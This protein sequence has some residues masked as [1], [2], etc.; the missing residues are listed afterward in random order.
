MSPTLKTIGQ[1]RSTIPRGGRVRK[2][3]TQ[4]V[5]IAVVGGAGHVGLPLSL[6]L[7][8]RGFHLTVIDHDRQK[9]DMLQRGQMPFL[10]E[11]ADEL[12]KQLDGSHVTFR[13]TYEDVASCD[14][15]ILTV[16]TPLDAHLN[17]DL[18][19]VYGVIEQLKA[20][21]HDGQVLV[22]RSTLFPGTSE[23]IL[24]MLRAQ[25][26]GIG[27]SFCP[28]RIAQGKAL[29]EL[30]QLPQLISASDRRTLEIV[31]SVFSSFN[32]EVIE[33]SMTEAE[34]A[35]LFTNAW[36]YIKF[37]IANQFYM[38]AVEKGLDFYRIRD[39]MTR[40]YERVAD[41]PLAGFAAGPCLLK[42]TM[43]LAA[44]NRQHFGVGHAAMLLN[45]TLPDFLVDQVKRTRSLRDCRVGILG[46]AF[47]AENDD[48]RESLAYKLRKLLLYEGAI[49]VC[50]DPYIRD[51]SF[52]PLHQVLETCELLFIGCPH[53][54]YRAVSFEGRD[55]VDCWG[56][57]RAQ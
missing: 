46:M 31:R 50:T 18:S 15:V 10:E 26:L 4:T 37:A 3:Q 6:V 43:Q 16:G 35:K 29:R 25:G 56:L 42:D 38:T 28:E 5:R 45:E 39:A 2:P 55:V 13:T 49:V 30:R 9:I 12:L 27:V 19:E 34:L 22:L 47:K 7:A 54:A 33:L 41:F 21:L 20:F 52:V 1:R 8:S 23:K 17:P 14:V 53:A 57:L 48:P 24:A 36:R 11:G 40:H 44:Y 51:P 32:S